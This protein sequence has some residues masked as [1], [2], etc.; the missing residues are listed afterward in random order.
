MT[1]HSGK[2]WNTDSSFRKLTVPSVSTKAGTVIMPMRVTKA[3][4]VE[5]K[6]R[7]AEFAAR[8]E[9]RQKGKR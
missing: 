2:E 9:K 1:P 3:V 4:A 7:L 8:K 6:K 5:G